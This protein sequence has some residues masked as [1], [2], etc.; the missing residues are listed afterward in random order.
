MIM[1]DIVHNDQTFMDKIKPSVAANMLLIAIVGFVAAFALWAGFAQ[2]DQVTRGTGRVIPSKQL[3]IVQNLEGGIVRDIAV[4]EGQSVKKGDVLLR[5]DST[6]LGADFAKGQAGYNALVAKITRLQAE[7]SFGAP[8]FPSSLVQAAPDIVS[9]EMTLFSA[10][11]SELS[12]N[13]SVAQS[14]LQQAEVQAQA[15]GQSARLAAQEVTMITPL[16]EKGIEPRIEL[17]RAQG[18]AQETASQT[19]AANSAVNQARS[20]VQA[21]RERHH[22]RAVEELAAAKGELSGQGGALPALQDRVT[23]TEV[24]APISG[25][26]NRV[27][28]ATVGGVVRPGEPLVEIV[29]KDDSL[30]VEA[31]I[32]PSDV[33]FL[34]PGQT[35][36]VKITAF[37]FSTYGGLEGVLEY[38][39]PDAVKDDRS[40]ET[41]YLV[42]V[43]TKSSV[44]QTK[45]GPRPIT[46]GMIAEV[47]VMNGKRSVLDYILSPVKNVSNRALQE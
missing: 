47:D 11:Q 44:L 29:P 24:K 22:S 27:L 4:V 30:V 46:A 5:M 36:M 18:R 21:V 6:Q 13:L 28:V 34:S 38:I 32:K 16:V 31:K 3:Q 41:H 9:A 14:H 39:S 20:E 1:D 45:Q 10:R 33:A 35:A 19:Q 7:A 17:I 2:L 15:A 8:S 23:R 42:R 40:G 43:R 26:V 37:N 12:A 25:T